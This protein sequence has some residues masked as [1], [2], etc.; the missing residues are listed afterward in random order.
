MKEISLRLCG[1]VACW[2]MTALAAGQDSTG[3]AVTQKVENPPPADAPPGIKVIVQGIGT[4]SPKHDRMTPYR[5][6]Q[7]HF[8]PRLPGGKHVMTITSKDFL[9]LRDQY[10][11]YCH[12]PTAPVLKMTYGRYTNKPPKLGDGGVLAKT[13]PTGTWITSATC[14]NLKK[15]TCTGLRSPMPESDNSPG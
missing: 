6:I 5:G 2:L 9:T 8:P 1:L 14:S 13:S 7:S 3:Q 11:A 4:S 15:F 12:G 10:R